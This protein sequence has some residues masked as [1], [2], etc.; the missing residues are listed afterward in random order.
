MKPRPKGDDRE[1]SGLLSKFDKSTLKRK[2]RCNTAAK[3]EVGHMIRLD[4]G[5]LSGPL[6][7]VVL[8]TH[9]MGQQQQHFARGGYQAACS[10]KVVLLI[11]GGAAN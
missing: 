9:E 10:S 2:L 4:R 6:D 5:Y 3:I 8:Q 7:R 11:S 1:R